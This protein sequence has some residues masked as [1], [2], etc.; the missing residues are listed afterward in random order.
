MNRC[1][2]ICICVCIISKNRNA[3]VNLRNNPHSHF[4]RVTDH[5][6]SHWAR[7]VATCIHLFLGS[8]IHHP[9]Q[10]KGICNSLLSPAWDAD[11]PL[12]RKLLLITNLKPSHLTKA[13]GHVYQAQVCRQFDPKI[14]GFPFPHPEARQEIQPNQ[15]KEAS[16]CCV[17]SQWGRPLDGLGHTNWLLYTKSLLSPSSRKYFPS[18]NFLP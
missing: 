3:A 10:R 11:I 12:C 18:V 8:N 4:P 9:G 14:L 15:A 16:E 7:A 13:P 2:G 5:S 17:H 1:V 6:C